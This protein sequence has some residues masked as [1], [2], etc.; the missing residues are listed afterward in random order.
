LRVLAERAVYDFHTRFLEYQVC[1]TTALQ[2]G[3][4][5]LLEEADAAGMES[6]L[7]TSPSPGERLADLYFEYHACRRF[8]EQVVGVDLETWV[9]DH[10][11]GQSVVAAVEDTTGRFDAEIEVQEAPS[12]T[13]REELDLTNEWPP[14]ELP[15]TPLEQLVLVRYQELI[16]TYRDQ[17]ERESVRTGYLGL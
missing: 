4:E 8:A 11:N 15:D 5:E 14:D 10:P 17:L 7:E 12:V 9:A 13:P 3:F 2:Q 1:R 6:P 16:E